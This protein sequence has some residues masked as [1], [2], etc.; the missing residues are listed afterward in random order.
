M[1]QVEFYS[2]DYFCSTDIDIVVIGARFRD[3]WIFVKSLKRACYEMPAGHVEKDEQADFAAA[4]E[5]MEETGAIKFVI[6]CINTY[7]VRIDKETKWGKLYLAYVL[8]LGEIPDK[9]E[10]DHIY[11]D[12][13]IP[14][15]SKFREVQIPLYKRLKEVY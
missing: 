12:D 8:E 14:G 3:Q 13:S 10:I 2:T 7:S 6:E 5:L 1:T 11:L 15:Y 9:K 4:R